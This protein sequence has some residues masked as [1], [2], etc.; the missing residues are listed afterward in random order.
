MTGSE[1]QF[2]DTE[3]SLMLRL[4]DNLPPRVRAD[5]VMRRV[6]RRHVRRSALLAACALVSIATIATAAVPGSVLNKYVR[7]ILGLGDKGAGVSAH[8]APAVPT[9]A[10]EAVAMRGIA[11]VPGEEAIIVFRAAQSSGEVRVRLADVPTVRI[12]QT[13]ERGDASFDLT[14][15]GV[16][17]G[18]VGSTASYEVVIP[19]TLARV[20]VMVEGRAIVTKEGAALRCGGR[21]ISGV[22]CAVPV[23][24]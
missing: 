23:R 18:N 7:G 8:P 24:R 5:D 13:T 20:T 19:T 9:Q 2:G 15:A 17:V 14:T 1:R 10:S 11:F 4:I 12:E 16:E 22:G 6:H 21:R 3:L